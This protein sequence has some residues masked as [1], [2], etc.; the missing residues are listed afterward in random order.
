M[1]KHLAQCLNIETPYMHLCVY[2]SKTRALLSITAPAMQLL[3]M[4]FDDYKSHFLNT[5]LIG[6][7]CLNIEIK[8]GRKRGSK[9]E[10]KRKK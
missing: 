2:V 5:D 8:E 7:Q 1:F 10:M 4:A 3:A 6:P 9:I